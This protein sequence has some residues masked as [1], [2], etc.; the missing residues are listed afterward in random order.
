[1]SRR[2]QGLAVTT[3]Q[4]VEGIGH[5]D[6]REFRSRAMG[7]GALLQSSGLAA[8]AAFLAAKAGPDE[9]IKRAYR[10]I[11]NALAGH[12][13]GRAG[14]DP[15]ECAPFVGWLGQIDIVEYR[16]ASADAHEFA[17]WVRRAAEALIPPGGSAGDA[18]GVGGAG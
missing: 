13:L 8:G 7:L 18:Q 2:D 9:P 5:R 1:M 15:L 6:R 16:R 4:L 12:V 10:D 17:I 11:G 14:A 3:W